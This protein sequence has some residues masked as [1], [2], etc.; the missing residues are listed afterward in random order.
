LEKL[1]ERDVLLANK[2]N[3]DALPLP[4]GGPVRL[5][6]PNLYAYK[7]PMWLTKITFIR[8]DK[9]GYWESGNYSNIAD[10][11]LESRYYNK[12]KT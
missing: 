7:S 3:G 10:A 4:L 11:W 8:E 9:L 2:L 6:V 5:I 1:L 12:K